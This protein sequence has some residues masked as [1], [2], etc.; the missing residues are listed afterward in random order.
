MA[1]REQGWPGRQ[2]HAADGGNGRPASEEARSTTREHRADGGAHRR[3]GRPWPKTTR[4]V[5]T[6]GTARTTRREDRKDDEDEDGC[7]P[8]R[9]GWPGAIPRDGTKRRGP[10]GGPRTA[11]TGKSAGTTRTTAGPRGWPANADERS[12]AQTA[13]TARTA[14]SHPK[15]Q[16]AVSQAPAHHQPPPSA[17]RH[18]R[19][20]SVWTMAHPLHLHHHP[21]PLDTSAEGRPSPTTTLRLSAREP[22]ISPHPGP[23]TTPPPRTASQRGRAI[24]REIGQERGPRETARTTP[25]REGR[26]TSGAD[27]EGRRPGRQ[28]SMDGGNGRPI[29]STTGEHSTDGGERSQGRTAR[30][31]GPRGRLGAGTA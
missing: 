25:P 24:R 22:G 18:E 4:T 13:R 8:G 12:G 21:S 30:V 17:S 29:R 27:R 6:A 19:G 3:E 7:P 28:E 10:R 23:P 1:D 20:G 26:V 14:L 2:D 9:R 16:R 31:P 5:K 11:R 15:R